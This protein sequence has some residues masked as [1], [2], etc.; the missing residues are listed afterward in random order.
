MEEKRE[1]DQ[2]GEVERGSEREKRDRVGDR[3]DRENKNEKKRRERENIEI[4]E[5]DEREER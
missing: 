1:K 3:I 5:R 2:T 4:K